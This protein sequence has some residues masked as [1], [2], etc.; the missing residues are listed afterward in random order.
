VVKAIAEIKNLDVASVAEQI[1][2]NF[3]G[4]FGIKLNSAE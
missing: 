2:E 3:E 1:I 4:F